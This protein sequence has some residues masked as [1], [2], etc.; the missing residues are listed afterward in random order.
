MTVQITQ[1]KLQNW[2][3]FRSVDLAL[4]QRMFIAGPNASGKTNLLD[5]LRFLHD[6]ARPEGNLLRAVK[7]RGG[8]AHVRSLHARQASN[9]RVEVTFAID[10]DQWTY[11]LELSGSRSRPLAVE[12]ERIEKNSSILEDRSTAKE[13]E[14]LRE[15][16]YL[17]QAAKNETFQPLV[18]ALASLQFVHVVPQVA[19]SA[20]RS[21]DLNL[22]IAPGSDFI[23]QLAK[24]PSKKQKGALARIEKVLRKAVPGFSTLQVERDHLGRPHLRANYQHWRAQGSWQNELDFS[25]GTLRLIGLLWAI[26]HG[27]APIILEEPELSLH[28]QVIR[29]LPRMFSRIAA[30][31]GRQF[32]VSTHA[33]EMLVDAGIEPN[34]IVLLDPTKT[35]DTLVS[36]GSDDP[37]LVSAARAGLSLGKMVTA[38]TSPKGI[39]QLSLAFGRAS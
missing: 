10:D 22:A 23:D 26:D 11:A 18:E 16:S 4:Q 28:R 21:D 20:A 8:I 37:E 36:L 9:I 31:S 5:A 33:E 15:Q 2:R 3:N 30:R 35:D 6:I 29:E 14:K 17:Q 25:D 19:R 12:K 24:L 39:E 13:T 34:E 32:L 27:T 7:D 1:L 38:R